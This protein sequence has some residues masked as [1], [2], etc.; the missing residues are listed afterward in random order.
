MTWVKKLFT[1][2]EAEKLHILK[3]VIEWKLKQKDGANSLWISDRQ[4][5]RLQ[6]EYKI[7]GDDC[8]IHGL[9]H[10]K[11]N[12]KTKNKKVI[13]DIAKEERFEWFWPT[14][15]QEHLLD[16]YKIKVSIE[17]V[18]QI[19]IEE[20]VWES[21]DRKHHIY[22]QAR[23]RRPNYWAMVQ[24]DWSYHKWFE[25]RNPEEFCALVSIDDATGQLLHVTLWEN[26]WFDCISKFWIEYILKHGIP[27]TIYLD[28]FSSYKVNHKKAVYD[29]RMI[30]NFERIM[31][32][33]WCKLIFANSPQAKWRV[34]KCNDTLQDRL[35][36]EMRLRRINEVDSANNFIEEEFIPSY[37]TKFAVLARELWDNHIE[38]WYK[39]EKLDIIFSTVEVR[40]LGQDYIIQYKNRY[41]QV[42]EWAYTVYPKK[43]IEV[44][45]S[46][47]W[48]IYLKI[49]EITVQYKELDYTKTKR[50]R[51]KFR[52]E[53]YKI[54]QEKQKIRFAEL[55][56]T[57]Y[58]ASKLIQTSE[59]RSK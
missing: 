22:R 42:L 32:K 50:Q 52:Y 25:D 54:E 20:H 14:L 6:K 26:E 15:L 35:V 58:E 7:Y 41:F 45:E 47:T 59:R 36:K 29:K 11:S 21:K 8:V 18:R 3:E 37:N 31:R 49:W 44:H 28:K 30:T 46:Y 33:L 24:F 55:Q 48:A 4:M 23:E 43:K 12:H 5:R 53:R 40:S 13:A 17:T 34:E 39:R 38:N 10:K 16:D 19:M 57:R 56:K 27:E 9:K 2:T 51:T 1:E